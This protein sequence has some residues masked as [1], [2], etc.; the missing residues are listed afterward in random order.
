MV[1]VMV[2]W[3]TGDDRDGGHGGD[4]DGCGGGDGGNDSENKWVPVCW[5]SDFLSTRIHHCLGCLESLSPVSSHRSSLT[6]LL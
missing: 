1:V 2:R 4:D 6:P 3:W 5:S